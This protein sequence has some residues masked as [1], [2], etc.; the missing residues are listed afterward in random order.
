MRH[1]DV[2][3]MICIF[4]RRSGLCVVMSHPPGG[5]AQRPGSP[6]AAQGRLRLRSTIVCANERSNV[7]SG[8]QGGVGTRGQVFTTSHRGPVLLARR[9]APCLAV[10]LSLV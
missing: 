6:G 10:A 9:G 3:P 1:G 2:M 7:V 8:V 5:T 4:I